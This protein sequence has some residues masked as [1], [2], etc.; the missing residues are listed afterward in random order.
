[1]FRGRGCRVRRS[2]RCACA[3]Q[4]LQISGHFRVG[5]GRQR[6]EVEFIIVVIG[7]ILIFEGLPWFLSPGSAKK[8][9]W[10]MALGLLLVYLV[11]G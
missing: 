1:M 4:D 2:K 6:I 3:R 7:I 10:L 9:L 8:V 11:R 5:P